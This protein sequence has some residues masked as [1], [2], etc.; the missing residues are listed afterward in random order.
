MVRI[1]VSVCIDWVSDRVLKRLV[2]T[3]GGRAVC[4]NCEH[5]GLTPLLHGVGFLCRI[6][7][8]DAS[9]VAENVCRD[10]REAKWVEFRRDEQRSMKRHTLLAV[11]S[12]LILPHNTYSKGKRP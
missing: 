4:Y 2:W 8:P 11:L 9:G 12:K 10:W 3:S 5:M 1:L 7:S 6:N